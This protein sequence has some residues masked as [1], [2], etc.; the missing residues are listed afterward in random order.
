MP[1]EL[2][3][4]SDEDDEEFKADVRIQYPPVVVAIRLIPGVTRNNCA[5]GI[6]DH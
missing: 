3:D 2:E 1:A 4:F 6:A 5:H